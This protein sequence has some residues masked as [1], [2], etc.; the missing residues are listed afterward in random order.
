[1]D[2]L[3]PLPPSRPSPNRQFTHP[4]SYRVLRT[5]VS[6]A[7]L[8][9]PLNNRGKAKLSHDMATLETALSSIYPK[10]SELGAPYHELRAFRELCFFG[11]EQNPVTVAGLLK[12]QRLTA[13]LR[14]STLLDALFSRAPLEMS[15]PHVLQRCSERTLVEELLALYYGDTQPPSQQQWQQQH[16]P[17][18]GAETAHWEVVQVC[19]DAYAQR[20]SA[21]QAEPAY[22]YDV[23][24]NL[25]PAL[26]KAWGERLGR[27]QQQRSQQRGQAAA[28]GSLPLAW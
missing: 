19:L 10:V 3:P 8:V 21:A 13:H 16:D 15:S 20:M 24:L 1:M 25:G 4:P 27:E 28:A 26:L 9:R 2:S 7:A 12:E 5:Y 11:D 23:M 22:L 17:R 18:L 14:P 6:H